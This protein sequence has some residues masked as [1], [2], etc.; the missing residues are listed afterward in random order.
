MVP[1]EPGSC[2]FVLDP[3]RPLH[4]GSHLEAEQGV[5][6]PDGR[7]TSSGGLPAVRYGF[8]IGTSDIYS[9]GRVHLYQLAWCLASRGAQVDVHTDR[10]PLWARDHPPLANLRIHVDHG[11]APPG[12]L[13]VI[14]TDGREPMAGAAL[15]IRRRRSRA[16]L[17]GMSFETYD[18][19]RRYV[20]PGELRRFVDRLPALSCC[21]LLLAAS[22]E[23]AR[24]LRREL[25]ERHLPEPPIRVFEPAVNSFALS[26]SRRAPPLALGRPY[27]FMVGR[28]AEHK[29]QAHAIEAIWALDVPFDLVHFGLLRQDAFRHDEP[30]HAL[31][32]FDR[33]PDVA[34]FRAM[35][36]AAFV[37]APSTFE[38]HGMVPAEAL[39]SGTPCIAYD[40]PVLRQIYRD[41]L[42]YVP[43][44]D[45]R[46]LTST[47]ARLVATGLPSA[48]CPREHL[49][50]HGLAA[51]R[52]RI[53]ALALHARPRRREL[54]GE[55][56]LGRAASG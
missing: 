17:V 1:R 18:W 40:L 29:N 10:E 3:E 9:G 12:E 20:S 28:P 16:R 22:A 33:A 41:R 23:S 25:R 8:W 46:A 6:T 15:E 11:E 56:P 30:L 49:R 21:D 34:K 44:N 31:H 43:W 52:R 19:V 7:D 5:A 26:A 27:A 45:A 13:D 47:V 37:L 38:G 54:D 2:S 53:E 55:L 24:W 50:R 32:V 42:I 48:G 35:R 51:Q 39:C 14:V 36:D 4:V